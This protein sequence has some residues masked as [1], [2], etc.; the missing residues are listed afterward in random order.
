MFLESAKIFLDHNPDILARFLI[1]GDGELRNDLVKCC[2]Q[3]GVSRYVKFCGWQTDLANVYADL[4]IV[5]LTSINEGTPVSIIEAMA[6]SVPVIS[7]DAGGVRDLLGAPVQG[8]SSNGFQV[9]ERGIL[10]QQGDVEGFAMGLKY[11]VENH[12]RLKKE[13]SRGARLFAEQNFA[14]E[15]LLHDIESLYVEL[16]GPQITRITQKNDIML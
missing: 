2:E 15:R 16:M 1:I 6:S 5:A 14:K 12:S 4:D 13:M 11:L 8:V 10:C 9:H 7:A 3:Q